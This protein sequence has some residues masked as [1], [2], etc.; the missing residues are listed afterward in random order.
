MRKASLS[1]NPFLQGKQRFIVEG[2]PEC[3]RLITR[4]TISVE[5][6][7][8]ERPDKTV[9]PAGRIATGEFNVTLDFADDLARQAYISWF[10]M[11]KDKVASASAATV[12]AGGTVQTSTST[13]SVPGI[14]PNYKK[15]ATVIYH[16]LY[17]DPGGQ[18]QPLKVRVYGCWPKSMTLPDL[19]IDGEECSTLEVAISYDDV[20]ILA[21]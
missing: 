1:P 21:N 9:V 11:C 3:S 19:D 2:L 6:G 7:V 17:Q 10:N 14:D 13:G 18:Q 12:E 16:R 15:T 20:D 4:D 8:I 5:L